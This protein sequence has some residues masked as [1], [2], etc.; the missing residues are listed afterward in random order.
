MAVFI[1]GITGAR[2]SRF[3]N[4]NIVRFIDSLNKEQ[5]KKMKKALIQEM[6]LTYNQQNK[7]RY[8]SLKKELEYINYRLS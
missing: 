5:L 1:G 6:R 3:M 8:Q 4:E 7:Q 2:A